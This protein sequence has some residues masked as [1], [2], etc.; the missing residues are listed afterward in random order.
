LVR[1]VFEV[2]GFAAL[3]AEKLCFSGGNITTT[4]ASPPDERRGLASP[5]TTRNRAEIARAISALSLEKITERQS[6]SAH[7][8]AQPQSI[9]GLTEKQSFSA[10]RTPQPKNAPLSR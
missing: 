8:A 2:A 9:I 1:E 4:A 5:L 3:F 7:R 10:N 6:L